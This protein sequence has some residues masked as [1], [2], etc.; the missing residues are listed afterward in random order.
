MRALEATAIHALKPPGNTGEQASEQRTG[1]GS[2]GRS[3]RRPPPGRRA[4]PAIPGCICPDPEWQ[5]T[6]GGPVDA[7]LES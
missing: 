5:P 1:A 2:M 7:S 4:R 3:R 6:R